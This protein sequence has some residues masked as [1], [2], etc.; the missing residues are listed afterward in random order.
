MLISHDNTPKPV[1]YPAF[2]SCTVCGVDTHFS[3]T[4]NLEGQETEALYI[5]LFYQLTTM[6]SLLSFERPIGTG[7]D[8]SE[9][10]YATALMQTGMKSDLRLDCSLT[11]KKEPLCVLTPRHT[12]LF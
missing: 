6:G 10:E 8:V 7:A 5:H 2:V 1:R 11:G 12:Y 9:L 3:H 4:F